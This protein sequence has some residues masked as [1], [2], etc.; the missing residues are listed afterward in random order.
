MPNKPKIDEEEQREQLQHDQP[1]GFDPDPREAITHQEESPYGNPDTTYRPGDP[2]PSQSMYPPLKAVDPGS[3]A[4]A[5][6]EEEK[7]EDEKD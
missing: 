7:N 1:S 3:A 4:A 5:S 2:P 6:K